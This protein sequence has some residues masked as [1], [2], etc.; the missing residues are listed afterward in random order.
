MGSGEDG[1]EPALGG[2]HEILTSCF[3]D[4]RQKKAKVTYLSAA[5]T[6]LKLRWRVN[7]TKTIND[8]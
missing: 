2:D 8:N 7:E 6:Y 5:S 1:S 4:L 3:T